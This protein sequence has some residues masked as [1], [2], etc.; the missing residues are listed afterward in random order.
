VAGSAGVRPGLRHKVAAVAHFPACA[1]VL[2]A[3]GIRGAVRGA[4]GRS[5]AADSVVMLA[6]VAAGM[7][8]SLAAAEAGQSQEAPGRVVPVLTLC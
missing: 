5:A 6:D 8:D 3:V 4:R 2:A 7:A 1:I